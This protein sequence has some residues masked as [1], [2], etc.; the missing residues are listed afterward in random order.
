MLQSR[1][2]FQIFMVVGCIAPLH[3]YPAAAGMTFEDYHSALVA[4][5]GEVPPELIKQTIIKPAHVALVR[6]QT[7]TVAGAIANL[8]AL[9]PGPLKK[10]FNEMGPIGVWMKFREPEL[11][12]I[13][14]LLGCSVVVL[15]DDGTDVWQG[16]M[17]KFLR[18][19]QIL[20]LVCK[21]KGAPN[22]GSFNVLLYAGLNPAS[23]KAT[24][25]DNLRYSAEAEYEAK[26]EDRRDAKRRRRDYNE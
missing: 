7:R 11:P 24:A 12:L 8:L 15:H 3:L 13:T 4:C 20:Y 10:V 21:W 9:S 2:L 6:G 25:E 26:K 18:G 17:G 19:Q 14:S 1:F 23:L 16:K 5:H 22:T